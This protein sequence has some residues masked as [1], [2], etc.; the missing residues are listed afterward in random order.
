MESNIGEAK[1]KKVTHWSPVW[2]FP[3]FTPVIGP[4]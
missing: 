2:I 1:N 4:W 3:I